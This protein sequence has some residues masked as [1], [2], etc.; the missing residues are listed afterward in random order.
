MLVIKTTQDLLQ[1]LECDN[2][3]GNG[4]RLLLNT[5]IYKDS[6]TVLKYLLDNNLGEPISY[7]QLEAA[8][9][10]STSEKMATKVSRAVSRLQT[11][12]SNEAHFVLNGEG[13]RTR[14]LRY[15][16]DG[17]TFVLQKQGQSHVSLEFD[18]VLIK[19]ADEQSN[20]EDASQD[21]TTYSDVMTTSALLPLPTKPF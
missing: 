1:I 10:K 11:G 16:G 21:N 17:S 14:C 5:S 9:P 12:L 2:E 4:G 6:R 15:N 8:F 18:C 13:E 20:S 19:G 3:T 7:L